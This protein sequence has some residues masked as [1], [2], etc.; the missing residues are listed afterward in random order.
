MAAICYGKIILKIKEAGK[1]MD[2]LRNTDARVAAWKTGDDGC[3]RI[4]ALYPC[5]FSRT[6]RKG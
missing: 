2:N 3:A 6:D 5:E 1:Q 4:F